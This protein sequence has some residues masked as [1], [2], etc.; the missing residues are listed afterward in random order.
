MAQLRRGLNA[1]MKTVGQPK[2]K[3]RNMTESQ[4]SREQQERAETEK[5][6]WCEFPEGNDRDML[7]FHLP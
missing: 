6:A 3:V 5:G 7:G 1:E 4:R 2:G